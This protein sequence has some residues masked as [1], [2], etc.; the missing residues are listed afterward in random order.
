[1]IDQETK[2]WDCAKI[3]HLFL[4]FEAAKIKSIPIC[5]TNQVDYI[6]WP[7]CRDG[8]YSVKTGYQLLCELDTQNRALGSDMT[9]GRVFW[10][11][12]WKVRVP[13]KIKKNL[14]RACSKA[15]PTRCNLLRRKMLE[16][17]TCPHC[18]IGNESTMHALWECNQLRTVWE[19][20]LGWILKDHPG[21]S[22]FTDLVALVGEHATQLELFA[23]IA[24]FIW[25]RR[26]KVRCNEPSTPLGKILESAASLLR[27]FQSHTRSG[28]KASTQRDIKWKP[29][30]GAVVKTNF[31]GAMFV[32]SDQAGI[33]VVVRNNRGQ[34]MVALAEKIPKPAS[35]ETLKVLAARR[36]VQFIHELG[37]VHSIFEGDAETVI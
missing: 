11:R 24:W 6:I 36:A 29:P 12:L 28:V 3:D 9:S 25:C 34:V 18:S 31:D 27:E 32:E 37:F 26:N 15:L 20:V 5:I 30:E 8:L 17:P 7:R 21:I 13:N 4:P 22:Q 33:G 1:M 19:K 23:T 10:R 16:D 2:Q 14:W 35:T